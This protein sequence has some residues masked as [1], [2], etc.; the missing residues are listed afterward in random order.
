MPS[1]TQLPTSVGSPAQWAAAGTTDPEC[2]QTNDG[3]VTF[4]EVAG[5]GDMAHVHFLSPAIPAA[6]VDPVNACTATWILKSPGG[7]DTAGVRVGSTSN[8]IDFPGITGVYA[9]YGGSWPSLAKSGIDVVGTKMQTGTSGTVN[10]RCTQIYRTVDYTM[11]AGG[12]ME[13]FS[14]LTP[15][16]GS[17][18][19][20]LQ[21]RG[22]VELA[23][24]H[25]RFTVSELRRFWREWVQYRHPS[26]FILGV[27]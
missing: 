4:L 19:T 3:D 7:T 18:L 5:A 2:V 14:V 17:G 9:G 21:F 10:V 12:F 26:Y 6:A 15:L 8:W 27:H 11:Q 16:V 13:F 1:L 23:L 24:R 20:W 22:A 25:T